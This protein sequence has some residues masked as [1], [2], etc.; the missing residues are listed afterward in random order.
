M[1]TIAKMIDE[2]RNKRPYDDFAREVGVKTP[3][4]FRYIKEERNM[5][6]KNIRL[7]AAWAKEQQDQEF[8]SALAAYVGIDISS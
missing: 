6:V 8:I 1:T 3:T 2:R 5:D 7:F 4:L